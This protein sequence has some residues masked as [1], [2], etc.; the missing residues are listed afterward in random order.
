MTEVL[1]FEKYNLP[2]PYEDKKISD[3]KMMPNGYDNLYPNFLLKLYNDSPIHHSIVNAKATYII[4][5]GIK[6]KQGEVLDIRVNPSETFTDFI[7]KCVKDYLIFN[8]FAVEVI[9]NALNQP[10][11]YYFVPAHRIRTNKLKTKFWYSEDFRDKKNIVVYDRWKPNN[12]TPESKIFFFDGYFPSLS[13]VYPSPEYTGSLKSIT[14]DIAIRD[15]NLNNVK[16][17]FSVSTMITFF[18]G[19]NVSDDV[20]KQIAKD[21]KDAHTGE[22]GNKII[23]DFQGP[24]GKASEVTNISPNDWDKAYSETLKSVSDDIYRGHQV[25]SPVLF[26]VKTEGQLGGTT[27]MEVAYEIF[28]NTY[29]RG[30]RN[31]LTS[32]LNLMFTG[33]TLI[34]DNVEF[35]ERPL[36]SSRVSDELKE[37]I[38]TVNELRQLAGKAPIEIGDKLLSEI[39]KTPQPIAPPVDGENYVPA[40]PEDLKKNSKGNLTELV[41]DDFDKVSHLG[42]H[43]DDFEIVKG[44][45]YVFSKEEAKQVQLDFDLEKDVA[46]WILSNDIRN[47]DL[48]DLA[49]KLSDAGLQVDMGQ[50]NKVLVSLNESGIVKTKITDGKVSIEESTKSKIPNSDEVFVMY[51]YVKRDG[52]SG[53]DLLDTSRGFCKKL[54]NNN[55][56]YSMEDIQTMSGIFG[57]EVFK[58]GGGFWH[59][60]D[61][62]TTTSHCRHKFKSVTV[63]RKKSVS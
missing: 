62:D 25:T 16:N 42:L 9:Y 47:L 56:Y 27:E 24:N 14:T 15:F 38:F 48:N 52:V 45:R 39:N 11:E 13:T 35:Q 7:G 10:I 22:N 8:Y 54:I 30:K 17:H 51:D 43:K 34:T 61:S 23:L 12:N 28:N 5:D 18:M 4:G 21:I 50:L 3:D 44:G 20:K 6:Y 63:K 55:R 1:K 49:G 37:K 19:S 33:S 60:P 26:G 46:D 32:A 2:Q 41:D 58:Y 59:N 40:Q 31:E 36:F 29:I 53:P 57:Y